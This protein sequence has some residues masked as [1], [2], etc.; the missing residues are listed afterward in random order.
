MAES[1]F[2]NGAAE[3]LEASSWRWKKHTDPFY[4]TFMMPFCDSHCRT[5]SRISRDY[6]CVLT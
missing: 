6:L 4:S 1:A 3:L 2:S 5:Q